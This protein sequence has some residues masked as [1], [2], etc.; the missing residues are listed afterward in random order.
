MGAAASV[1]DAGVTLVE[2]RALAGDR[3]DEDWFNEMADFDGV[4][5]REDWE[6]ASRSLQ[7]EEIYLEEFNAKLLEATA[8]NKSL[9]V[10]DSLGGDQSKIDTYLG[11]QPAVL[12]EAKKIL[13]EASIRKT[14]TKQEVLE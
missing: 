4:C 7:I 13:M 11:Y 2:A 3:F 5:S 9:L 10:L 14:K 6:N 12:V 8:Q 1:T